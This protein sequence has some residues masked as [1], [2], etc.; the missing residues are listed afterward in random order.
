MYHGDGYIKMLPRWNTGAHGNFG[1]FLINLSWIIKSLCARSSWVVRETQ[2]L[3]NALVKY[4][5]SWMSWHAPSITY[6]MDGASCEC[7]MESELIHLSSSQTLTRFTISICVLR[8]SQ[9]PLSRSVFGLFHAGV[10]CNLS[11]NFSNNM[12][13][14]SQYKWYGLII[15]VR[16]PSI[17]RNISLCVFVRKECVNILQSASILHSHIAEEI[18]RFFVLIWEEWRLRRVYNL[19][20]VKVRV[21]VFWN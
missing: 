3:R 20:L 2:M 15:Y 9:V 19:G 12:T 6:V 21:G 14:E 18:V 1:I 11:I 7:L 13:C 5:V 17:L 16:L 8:W 10:S 4:H